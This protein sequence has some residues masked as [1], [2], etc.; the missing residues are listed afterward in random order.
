MSLKT[1]RE[2]RHA[3]EATGPRR[4]AAAPRPA[5]FKQRTRAGPPPLKPQLATPVDR[6]PEGSQW[7]HEVKFDG[8]RL[9]CRKSGQAVRLV[10][11][12]G[13]DWTARFEPIA[14]QLRTLPVRDAILDGEVVALSDNGVS[15]F[16]RLQNALNSTSPSELTYFVFDLPWCD[17]LDLQAEPLVE[18]KRRLKDILQADA[19]K[20]PNVRYCE[21]VRSKGSLLLSL[22][23]RQGLE[24]LVSK[25]ADSPYEQCRSRNWLKSKCKRRQEFLIGGFTEPTAAGLPCDA[26][27]LGSYEPSGGLRYCGR[28]RTGFNEA[29][30]VALHNRLKLLE[31]PQSPFQN[32]PPEQAARRVHW[33]RP[34]LVAEVSFYE[35]TRGRFLRRPVFHGLRED[36][37]AADVVWEARVIKP[38]GASSSAIGKQSPIRSAPGR[39]G[40]R[41]PE[42]THP[43]RILF[44]EI[45]LTKAGLA[46]YYVALAEFLLPHVANRPM[47]LIRC[48]YGVTGSRLVQKDWTPLLPKAIDKVDIRE[49]GAT[50]PC[51]VVRD[52]AGLLALAQ[53]G[54]IELHTWGSSTAALE[55]PDR[56]IFDLDPEPDVTWERLA[57]AALLVRDEL[58]RSGLASF[59]KTSGGKGLHVVV[60]LQPRAA[61]K[62]AKAF[63]RSI[64]ER[65]ARAW[66]REFVTTNTNSHH[67]GRIFIDYR[68]NT[69]GA[70]CV[71]TFS[72]RARGA[73][74]VSAP[75]AWG[76]LRELGAGDA[77]TIA[78]VMTSARR[79]AATWKRLST[80]Q[81]SLTVGRSARPAT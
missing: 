44:P 30:L 51:I 39:N 31:Q 48:P 34:T 65:L 58:T 32:P 47:K 72:L 2:K 40:V 12:S 59:A 11:R 76:A 81:Q 64:A 15:D 43:E 21:H 67:A 9:I 13:E 52:A 49:K 77:L 54:A 50:R 29:S 57:D 66:P 20:H 61:W 69:R 38:A 19:P 4:N 1:H 35:A 42:L 22:A 16:Q 53:I 37:P 79:F 78:D 62:S 8:Y 73:A 33:V 63:S 27:L 46:D 28:V 26:L 55:K 45:G 36:K 70:T 74:P 5:L 25:R 17:G 75:V 6:P 18:R 60:P 68:R 41:R 56:L 71:A 80:L 24:G 23:H 10:T 14:R 7:I 3:V